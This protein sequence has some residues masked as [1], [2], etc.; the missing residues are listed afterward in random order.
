MV[1]AGPGNGTR[2]ES[3]GPA[4]HTAGGTM[5]SRPDRRVIIVG[6]DWRAMRCRSRRPDCRR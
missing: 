4:E 1:R 3:G 5:K 6:D 2:T